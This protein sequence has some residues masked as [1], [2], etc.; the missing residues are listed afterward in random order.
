MKKFFKSSL[1]DM[2]NGFG[3]LFAIFAI[4]VIGV[5]FL[6]GIIQATPD[7][8]RTM[9]EWYKENTVY[10]IDVKGGYGLSD[11]DVS[12]IKNILPD[13]SYVS[14]FISTD[15]KVTCGNAKLVARINGTDIS[16]SENDDFI[17]K[18]TVIEG[19]LPQNENEC[20]VERSSTYFKEISVGE[21]I[22]LEEYGSFG[23]VYK[24]E[25]FTVT[26]I[27]STPTYYY[28]DGRETSAVGGGV[29]DCVMYTYTE[30]YDFSSSSLAM[31]GSSY[32]DCYVTL[33]E[34]T[35]DYFD[36]EYSEYVD[37]FCDKIKEL[38]ATRLEAL[39]DKLSSMSMPK[40]EWYVL[41]L[42][43]A[44][45]SFISFA[46]NVDKVSD[47]A[48]IFP[49]FFIVVA[50]LVSLTSMTRMVEEGRAQIGTL[51]SFGYSDGR[52]AWK[53]ISY[54]LVAAIS[55]CGVGIAIGFTVFP[56]VIWWTYG[57][58]YVLPKLNILFNPLFAIIVFSVCIALSVFVTLYSCISTLKERP[59]ALMQPK[60]PKPG[61][62]ILLERV[63]FIWNNM[64]F[65]YKATARNIFRYK[66]NMFMTIISVMGCTALILTG[67]GLGNSIDSVKNEQLT[68]IIEY[69]IVIEYADNSNDELIEL[70]ETDTDGYISIRSEKNSTEFK[71]SKNSGY[72]TVDY[73]ITDDFLAF[74]DY[75][76]FDFI[77]NDDTSDDIAIVSE[78]IAEYFGLK[79][80]D[81]FTYSSTEY[82][83]K[84]IKISGIVKNYTGSYV[85]MSAAYYQRLFGEYYHNAFLVKKEV[86]EETSGEFGEK[87]MQ[88][89]ATSV[90]FT[91][92]KQRIY[93][94]LSS[95]LTAII[96]IIVV[97][98]GALSAIVLY[99]LTNINIEERRREIATLKVLGYTKGEV[100]G[101]IYRESVILTLTGDLLGLGLG[102]VMHGFIITKIDSL[103]MI[104]SHSISLYSFLIAF[105]ITL[106]FAAA[107]YLFMSIKLNNIQMVDSLKSNE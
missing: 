9:N 75:V 97:G 47:I 73:F 107:V 30:A 32:T 51:K 103:A 20:V 79:T 76:S 25:S 65:K 2:K 28:I 27:V 99:N 69:D 88:K 106:F 70:L 78:N 95:A 34:K 18:F 67:F 54:C 50:G 22:I 92:T 85:Y 37:T 14:A 100:A 82:G 8:R 57:S 19:R 93:D 68:E 42:S 63:P 77:S 44:N 24:S 55:G 74:S 66:K 4:I 105:G 53:Y 71:G 59:A 29:V 101:Y 102:K 6:V 10:D 48:G 38:S 60:A 5:G 40:A 41:G 83:N 46:M 11:D 16:R 49:I 26:G 98:A 86:N 104:F 91:Y 39:N 35:S 23:D 36:D 3:R 61:K 45:M 1:K 58:L 64:S 13:G 17:N 81:S 87:L 89:G 80:G 33:S 84:T 72:E 12:A 96:I 62:R 7:M 43:S 21:T 52:I 94:G 56:T 15:A 90:E 31:I